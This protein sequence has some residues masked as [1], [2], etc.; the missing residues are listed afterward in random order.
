MPDELPTTTAAEATV[1]EAA[2]ATPVVQTEASVTP[3]P[4]KTAETPDVT[5]ESEKPRPATDP[6]KMF[7]RRN[8][9]E[10]AKP[11]GDKP[12]DN[13]PDPDDEE[14]KLP[15]NAAPHIRTLAKNYDARKREVVR[16]Q[17]ELAEARKQP[18]TAANQAEVAALKAQIEA[19]KA[20]K[21]EIERL[22]KEADDTR[23]ALM[24]TNVRE[25]SDYRQQHGVLSKAA[26]EVNGILVPLVKDYGINADLRSLIEEKRTTPGN[27]P[28]YNSVLTALRDSGNAAGE[29]Y[30]KSQLNEIMSAQDKLYELDQ[31]AQQE[32]EAW[33]TNRK[34]E[35]QKTIGDTRKEL[36]ALSP[37]HNKSSQ[38]WMSLPE[39]TRSTISAME[40][41]A[42]E[43][44]EQAMEMASNPRKLAAAAYQNH[45]S[46]QIAHNAHQNALAQIEKVSGEYQEYKAKADAELS[47]LRSK[48]SGYERAAQGTPGGV[49]RSNP[50]QTPTEGRT[51]YDPARMFPSRKAN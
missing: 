50:S 30:L 7:S 31:K 14:P 51:I 15:A 12:Q 40:K 13:T 17:S 5:P 46:L 9:G 33:Q 27:R 49:A 16:L 47:A 28:I 6:A 35:F 3:V 4:E 42:E 19:S 29:D 8:S 26:K 23:K 21:V 25:T 45:F 37:L 36:A 48:L 18:A 11:A 32:Q 1:T 43:A 41:I 38:E 44:A 24:R 34:G 2:P 10:S 39:E 22:R 20:D